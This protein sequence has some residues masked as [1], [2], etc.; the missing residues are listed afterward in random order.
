VPFIIFDFLRLIA[1]RQPS[2]AS[3]VSCPISIWRHPTDI[4]I[5]PYLSLSPSSDVLVS[6]PLPDLDLSAAVVDSL[7]AR[8]FVTLA[9][10][11][12]TL[13]GVSPPLLDSLRQM[14]DLAYSALDDT[15]FHHQM[16]VIFDEIQNS[17]LPMP[18]NLHGLNYAD[19]NDLSSSLFEVNR[20]A[21][22]LLL[23]GIRAG[24]RSPSP[25]LAESV[26]EVQTQ[27]NA[28]SFLRNVLPE[29]YLFA[30]CIAKSF[31]ADTDMNSLIASINDQT[32]KI[33][34]HLLLATA[35]AQDAVW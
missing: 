33:T 17:I 34:A 13:T 5:A 14:A 16:Q 10:E 31:A 30:A 4:Q 11:L 20:T 24:L 29:Q 26:R 7:Q 21:C 2:I 3:I 35:H 15:E 22:F 25:S 18:F 23:E 12:A 8:Q 32:I 28:V 1:T 6:L 19:V 27:V 9:C